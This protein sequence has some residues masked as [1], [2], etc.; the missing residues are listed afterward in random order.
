MLH[1]LLKKSLYLLTTQ[2]H[3]FKSSCKPSKRND[4]NSFQ[5]KAKNRYQ[6]RR[7]NAIYFFQSTLYKINTARWPIK[8]NYCINFKVNNDFTKQAKIRSVVQGLTIN[9]RCSILVCCR[10]PW[11][12][13]VSSIYIFLKLMWKGS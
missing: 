9:S 11:Q 12:S 5:R 7:H 3:L 4:K 6:K 8:K 10:T 1:N 2:T 13:S